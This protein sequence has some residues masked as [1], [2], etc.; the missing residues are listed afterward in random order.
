[1]SGNIFFEDKAVLLVEDDLS[2]AEKVAGQLSSLG[3]SEV[4]IAT[5]L[6][7]AQDVL[8]RNVIDAAL[9]DINLLAGET[10]FELGWSLSAEGVAVVFFFS[11]FNAQEMAHAT[12]GY[13]FMEKPI[14][15]PRLKAALQRAIL[16]VASQPPGFMRKKMAGQEARQW[17]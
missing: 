16:R 7:H 8:T 15:L 17:K 2:V 11:G 3:Y 13:E 1:M 10:T 14:S 12:R 9:L 4:F 6:R 5:N